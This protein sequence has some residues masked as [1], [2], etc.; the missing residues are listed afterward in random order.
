MDK[1][2]KEHRRQNYN[3]KHSNKNKNKNFFIEEIDT[4]RM[5]KNYKSKKQQ[6][7]ENELWED[8]SDEVS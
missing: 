4:H 6:L 7:K 3:K 1:D 8:W 5:S 2:R